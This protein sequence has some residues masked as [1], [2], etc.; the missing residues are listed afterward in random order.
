MFHSYVL[1]ARAKH[2]DMGRMQFLMDKAILRDAVAQGFDS[3]Q[4][5]YDFYVARHAEK[6]GREFTPH[7]DPSWD[8]TPRPV[9]AIVSSR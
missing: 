7:I 8:E 9:L 5:V 2:R 6:Y 4:G 3:D 1:N